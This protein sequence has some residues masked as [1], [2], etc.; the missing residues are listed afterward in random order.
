MLGAALKNP[1]RGFSGPT[2]YFTGI[3]HRKVNSRKN[4]P[5]RGFAIYMPIFQRILDR[6]PEDVGGPQLIFVHLHQRVFFSSF[7][8]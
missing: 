4:G 3:E 7:S 6:A 2:I 1:W 5:H 8:L